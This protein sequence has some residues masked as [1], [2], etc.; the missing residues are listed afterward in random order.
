ML[1]FYFCFKILVSTRTV[2]TILKPKGKVKGLTL[3]DFKT[4]DK[5]QKSRECD[6]GAKI[7]KWNI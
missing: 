7:E 4:Y 1:V 5:L 3:H 2:K 6:R